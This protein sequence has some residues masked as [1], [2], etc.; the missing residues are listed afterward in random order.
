VPDKGF[1]PTTNI[2]LTGITKNYGKVTALKELSLE[3]PAG[4]ASVLVGPSGCGKSTLLRLIAGFIQP[5]SGEIWFGDK[6]VNQLPPEKRP[7]SLV[8]QNYALFPHKTVF[9][10]IAFGLRV[11]H[12]K[13][14]EIKGRVKEMLSLVALEGLEKRYP[15]EL[16]GGQQQ[17]VALA[18]SLAIS[19]DILLLDEPLSNLDAQTRT[20]MRLELKTWQQKL[21]ITTLYVTHD[22]EEALSLAD[23]LVVM[24][25]GVV[26]QAASPFEVYTSPATAF[27]A[28]FIGRRNLLKGKISRLDE[29]KIQVSLT[30]LADEISLV[31]LRANW[32][33]ELPPTPGQPVWVTIKPEEIA[34]ANAASEIVENKLNGKIL[35]QSFSGENYRLSVTTSVGKLE[36]VVSTLSISELNQNHLT[37]VLPPEKLGFLVAL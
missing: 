7:T 17:R 8:F 20:Q 4:Q 16:S 24:Q 36:L 21:G 22:Q 35:N 10:N 28:E 9:E 2:K 13:K 34:I 37:V 3:F 30:A 26:E 18:R 32:K 27:V 12:W 1:M 5:D 14:G 33:S 23:Q 6:L 15:G 19:P 11:R 31:G 29:A 25:N